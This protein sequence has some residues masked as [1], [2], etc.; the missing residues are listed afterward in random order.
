MKNITIDSKLTISYLQEGYKKGIF[1]PEDIC[2]EI[3]K[4]ASE[5]VDMNIWIVPPSMTFMQKYIDYIKTLDKEKALLWGIP[6]A[7]KDN[8]DLK[9]ICTTAGC[10]N[11]GYM[12]EDNATVVELLIK[13]GAIPVGKTN[14]DQFATGLVGTRS[15]FGETHNSLKQEMISG[16]SSS[17]SAVSVAMG[18]A[19][20]A[21]GTDTAGSGRV[22]AALNDLVGFKGSLGA[23]STKGV[24][25][26]CASLDC[27][28]AFTHNLEDAKL[29][30]QV[31]WVYDEKCAWSKKLDLVEEKTPHKVC[32]PDRELVFYGDYAEQYKMK[33][34]AFVKTVEAMNIPIEY[35]DYSM[36][37]EAAAILYDGP[38]IAERWSSLGEFVE[39]NEGKGMVPVTET[40]LKSGN[41]E[42]L[43]ADTLFK[44][45]H[46]LAE[47]KCEV[48]AILKDSILLL[49]TCGGTYTRQQVDEDPIATNSNMGL[50]TNHC[51]LL[52]LSALAFQAGYIEEGIPFGIT[53]FALSQEDGTNLAFAKLWQL[54]YLKDE[55]VPL[56]VCGLHM[57]GLSLSSQLIDLGAEFVEERKTSPNYRLIKLSTNPS[58]PGLIRVDKAG[59]QIELEI[60]NIPKKQLGDFLGMISEPLGL[61]RVELEDKT[62]VLGFICEGYMQAKGEDVSQFKSW[63]NVINR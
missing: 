63:R 38:W 22:P 8:I 59:E 45:I 20:F 15:L 33:W 62:K 44:A 43:K 57:R 19:A 47:I 2:Q 60:W 51:N 14:L 50:Y 48:R 29:V 28:T 61:G 27:V 39:K 18:Q 26:A 56:A 17:G 37:A 34:K 36:F 31:E 24:V 30:N 3:V 10:E 21:L 4:R 41:R 6:F 49:P 40:I 7:V 25:P 11:F 46:R 35:V 23:W 52:D 55:M 5:T 12:P 53:S 9:G 1:T 13:A 16:G 32:L 54:L 58:K 42:D